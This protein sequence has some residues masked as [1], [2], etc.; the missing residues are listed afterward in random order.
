MRH[1]SFTNHG[2][3]KINSKKNFIFLYV[4]QNVQYKKYLLR[5]MIWWT[6][7]GWFHF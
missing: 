1:V 2:Y 6:L 4:A 7:A 5:I 3:V